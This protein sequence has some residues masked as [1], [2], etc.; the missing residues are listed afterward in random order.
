MH[1]YDVAMKVLLQSPAELVLSGL[2]A[3]IVKTW[4]NVELP[5]VQNTRVDLVGQ[6]L[7]GEFVHIEIQSANDPAMPLRMAEYAL[8]LYRRLGK[9]PYQTVLY[10]G[11][12]PLRMSAELTH[13]ELRFKYRL[14]DIREMDGQR[15]LESRHFGDNVIG[16][17]ARLPDRVEAV[18][19]VLRTIAALPATE[20]ES[21]L[22]QLL[23]LS[24]LR[25]MEEL[26][27]QEAKNMPILND[28]MDHKV[29]GREFKRGLQQGVQQGLQ[30][31]VRQGVQQGESRLLRKQIEKRFGAVPPWVEERLTSMSAEELEALSVRLLDA[32]TLHE[33]LS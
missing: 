17:L 18:R 12:D 20:R 13:P 6:T 11:S 25:Q 2:N 26:V 3:G 1:E 27:E 19:H 33:L 23:I 15:L 28:I 29:L 9:F 7:A 22:K 10:V 30:E 21:A 8:R 24:G 32:Q 31:G 16:I 5:E 4:L 14:V